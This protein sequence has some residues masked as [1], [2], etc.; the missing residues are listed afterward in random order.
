[1]DVSS[2]SGR[3]PVHDFEIICQELELFVPPTTGEND[4]RLSER[5]KL[6]VANKIDALDEPERLARLSR[7][8]AERGILLFPVSA[9][10]GEG[11]SALV[12]ALWKMIKQ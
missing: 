11:L 12:E 9:V 5:P 7:S 8:M 4:N 6:V 10:T 1:V 2:A 3:D